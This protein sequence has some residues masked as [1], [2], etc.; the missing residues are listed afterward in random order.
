MV[1]YT[2]LNL[3]YKNKHNFYLVS[4]SPYNNTQHHMNLDANNLYINI[5]HHAAAHFQCE[6]AAPRCLKQKG[7]E[8]EI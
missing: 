6:F 7:C 4:H 5:Q 1:L 3:N 8:K 2:N